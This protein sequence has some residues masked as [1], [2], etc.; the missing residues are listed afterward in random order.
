MP[1]WKQAS[2]AS[3]S[4]IFYDD[5]TT[6]DTAP[7]TT[8]RI[9]EPGP[10]KIVYIGAKPLTYSISDDKLVFTVPSPNGVNSW[11]LQDTQGI[12][13]EPAGHFFV[14]DGLE[15]AQADGYWYGGRW[16]DGAGSNTFGG[17]RL[18]GSTS[19]HPISSHTV[20]K[21]TGRSGA[22]PH[23]VGVIVVGRCT[24]LFYKES[25]RGWVLDDIRHTYNYC[26]Q[27]RFSTNYSTAGSLDKVYI[28]D[29]P[30]AGYSEFE[31]KDFTYETVNM[32]E[33]YPEYPDTHSFTHEPDFWCNDT[34]DNNGEGSGVERTVMF[35]RLDDSNCLKISYSDT[36]GKTTLENIVSGVSQILYQENNISQGAALDTLFHVRAYGSTV[37]F[38]IN[39]KKVV[40]ATLTSTA[41]NSNTGGVLFYT[42]DDTVYNDSFKVY[43]YP[44]RGII[45][46]GFCP[47]GDEETDVIDPNSV[48]H[49]YSVIPPGAG[50]TF[51]IHL[52]KTESGSITWQMSDDG[53][54]IV[55][56]DGTPLYTSEA[57]EASDESDVLI[58][59]D[60]TELRYWEDT[61]LACT[62][63]VTNTTG[64]VAEIESDGGGFKYIAIF[65]REWD[66]SLPMEIR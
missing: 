61:T 12:Y 57:G 55:A 38:F 53:T 14:W 44:K 13:K 42:D 19:I 15:A 26:D 35:R 58:V 9:C 3:R 17:W 34:W 22:G 25:V 24:L 33:T 59:L 48:I 27:L 45:T 56:E 66:D 11:Y 2:G 28:Y 7:V 36:S 63:S 50:E 16:W 30:A 51:K 47:P 31:T 32:P 18:N 20:G 4:F 39:Y 43:P 6:P 49:M 46:G 41:N 10:G 65:K 62:V 54:V 21:D 37:D 40:T 52:R 23:T 8:P 64:T 29:L 60:G 1:L 5:F